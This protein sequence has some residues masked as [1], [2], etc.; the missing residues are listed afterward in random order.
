MLQLESLGQPRRACT[1]IV[2]AA[3][4]FEAKA[5]TAAGGAIFQTQRWIEVLGQL[6]KRNVHWLFI[7][8]I[9]LPRHTCRGKPQM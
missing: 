7:L 8:H 6:L 5:R 9:A 2:V 1:N 4:E 3:L